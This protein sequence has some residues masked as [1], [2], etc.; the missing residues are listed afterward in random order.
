LG[1]LEG[2]ET[3]IHETQQAFKASDKSPE[4]GQSE[5]GKIDGGP[6]TNTRT[7]KSEL[8]EPRNT[9][10]ITSRA[11]ELIK[12]INW[13]SA[14]LERKKLLLPRI[15]KREAEARKVAARVAADAGSD[16]YSRAETM[17]E[18]RMHRAFMLYVAAQRIALPGVK[19]P[20]PPTLP[21][22]S[23]LPYPSPFDLKMTML[24]F[25]SYASLGGRKE[26]C[27]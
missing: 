6:G 23:L 7:V 20:Q 18:R 13:A 12:A 10:G 2:T 4:L 22:K 3:L 5:T 9:D 19:I 11:N 15:E 27:R 1:G 21:S 8:Q 14:L 26:E 16:R 17:Y 25:L 24:L